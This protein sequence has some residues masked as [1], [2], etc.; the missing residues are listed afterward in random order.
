MTRRLSMSVVLGTML[1]VGA[2]ACG[3][4]DSSA[5]TSPGS[6]GGGSGENTVSVVEPA[7][8][9]T[10]QIP[11]KLQVKSGVS[12]GTTESGQHH[13]HLYF[14]GNDKKYEVVESDNME[15]TSSSK[16]VDGLQPGKHEL[17]ISLRNADHSA[18]GADTKIMVEVGGSGGSQP[19]TSGGGGGGGGY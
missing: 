12:L 18:A 8:G 6:G 4:D 15:I 13:V 5:N 10:I 19:P 3:S 7:D 9:S 14:D 1:L 11:F 2:T 16:A 17:N